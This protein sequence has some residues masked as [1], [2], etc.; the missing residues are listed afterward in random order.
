MR[1]GSPPKIIQKLSG[2]NIIADSMGKKNAHE[3]RTV[4]A[5][6]CV[7]LITEHF[8]L[9]LCC[10]I[11]PIYLVFTGRFFLQDG[12]FHPRIQR[13]RSDLQESQKHQPQGLQT[14]PLMPLLL[15]QHSGTNLSSQ[16][17]FNFHCIQIINSVV[18]KIH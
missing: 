4:L 6:N 8:S 16:P 15:L 9:G 3:K 11:F 5:K 18:Q 7:S 14:L 13:Q 10:G 2:I 1:A 12:G 17:P